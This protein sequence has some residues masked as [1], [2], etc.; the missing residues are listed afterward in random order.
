MTYWTKTLCLCTV[1]ALSACSNGVPNRTTACQSSGV[2]LEEMKAAKAAGFEA[3]SAIEK[4]R[5]ATALAHCLG[6]PDPTIRDGLAYEGLTTLLRSGT[7]ANDDVRALRDQ[8]L[9]MTANND[10]NGFAAPFAALVLSEVA[11]TDRVESY[12]TEAE[13]D[14]LVGAAITYVSDVQDYRGFS[15]IDGW[16]HGV[17][18]GADWLMQLSLNSALTK[19]QA[20]RILDTA[21]VQIPAASG[22]AYIH[23]EPGRLA[24][25]VIFVAMR[26]EMSEQDWTDWL[27]PLVDP[28]PMETWGDAFKSEV[29]LARLHDVKAFLQ[30]LYVGANNSSN[31]DVKALLPPVTEAL[32]ALP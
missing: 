24:R 22:H 10:A 20:D 28:A 27:T 31:T 32:R 23:G 26:G 19:D 14:Q 8:L 21:R 5:M 7:L 25:P 9:P 4:T 15:D 11:R 12:L 3:Q 17:A 1:M 16:R 18:H 2:T 30:A 29:G 6:H 13:I